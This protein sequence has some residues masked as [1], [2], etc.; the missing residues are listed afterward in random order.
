MQRL[1]MTYDA[2]DDFDD[3]CVPEGDLRRRAV[4]YRAR[5]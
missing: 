2:A 4:I 3:P 1:G 5:R